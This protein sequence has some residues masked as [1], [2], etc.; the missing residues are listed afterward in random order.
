[1]TEP[2]TLAIARDYNGL[3]EAI[4]ARVAALD[5]PH[6]AL[7]EFIGLTRGH[8]GK[9]LGP[10]E[11]K[12]IGI[13]T[14]W[15]MFEALGLVMVIGEHL[16]IAATIEEMGELFHRRAPY[17]QR[18]RMRKRVSPALIKAAAQHYGSMGRG[19]RKT[20]RLSPRERSKINR[21]N[22]LK[23][24]WRPVSGAAPCAKA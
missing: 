16:D 21:Q 18:G 3:I 11:D 19:K 15:R 12:R 10:A 20:F 22:V 9:L 6:D 4:R 13:H 14:L 23:R 1:M 8:L 24:K 7:E 17:A 2:R 5:A